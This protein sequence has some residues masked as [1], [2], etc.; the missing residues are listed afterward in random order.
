MNILSECFRRW[1]ILL[2]VIGVVILSSTGVA[3]AETTVP[4]DKVIAARKGLPVYELTVSAEE[5]DSLQKSVRSDERRPA[6]FRADGKEY[7]VGIRYRGDWART[8][9]KKPLKIFFEKGK[10]FEGQHAL[11][12]NSNWRDPAFIREQLAYEIYT[13]CGVPAPQT[14]MVKLN[15]NGQFHGV[16]LQVEQPSKPFLRRVGLKGAVVY[17]CDSRRW[18]SDMSDL[19]SEAAFREHYEKQTHKDESYEDLQSF[20]HDLA[21]TADVVKFFDERVDVDRY[22]SFLAGNAL[23]QNWDW[24]SKNHVLVHDIEGSK[25]WLVVPWD[26]D[27][28]LGDHWAGGFQSADLPLRLGTREQ[29][30]TI[31]W[32]KLYDAFYNEPSL[33]KRLLDRIGILLQKEF[34][35]E[36]LFPVLDTWESEIS[37]DVA[38]DRK[39]WPSHGGESFHAGIAGVKQ[40]ITDR[41]SY[42]SREIKSQ[43]VA[44]R[45][46]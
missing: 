39:R 18:K 19:G 21:T 45:S 35:E 43:R 23:V 4:Q 2:R 10:E 31:G 20:C 16:F 7:S 13:R 22:V 17:K 25:K 34:R 32:N 41:R 6:L 27:R 11:N 44:S 38:M 1:T 8:W 24:F 42:L 29:P 36:K 15:I 12:L 14:R 9:P 37:A 5:W 3:L 30:S 46:R 33:R 40:Y 28:T 26:L